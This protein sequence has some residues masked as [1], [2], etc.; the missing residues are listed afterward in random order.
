MSLKMR[1]ILNIITP[2][3]R[4][5]HLNDIY[6]SISENKNENVDIRWWIIFDKK[7]N[8]TKEVHFPNDIEIHQFFSKE[9]TIAGHGHRNKILSIL[10]TEEDDKEEEWIYNLDDDNIIHPG[11]IDYFNEIVVTSNELRIANKI[12]EINGIIFSQAMKDGRLRL[13]ADRNN[14]TLCNVDT[15]QFVFK[16]K[17]L[18]GLRF[19][20]NYCADGYFIEELYKNNKDNFFVDEEVHCYYNYLKREKEMNI[21]NCPVTILQNEFEFSN[22][23]SIY[24]YYK[25]KKVLEIG[26]FFGGTLWHW[27]EFNDEIETIVSIDYPIPSSDGRYDEMIDSKK[28]WNDWISKH[29]NISF[30][31]IEKE[32]TKQEAIDQAKQIFKND[33]VDFLFID[34][35]HDY[36]TV[37]SDFENYS[38]LVRKGGLIV[39]HDVV[40]CKDVMDLW[41]E[42]KMTYKYIEIFNGEQGGMGIGIIIK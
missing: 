30:F 10:E 17:T 12:P 4:P 8:M 18:N 6:K 5:N 2:C 33:D 14:I 23:L 20:D 32:S 9:S 35:G 40:G 31:S 19:Y 36:K 26:T 39:L 21:N 22:L 1:N 37:K 13:L 28:K 11:F 41:A 27:L 29:K 24:Q 34:G 38:K 3:T 7:A 42:I 25:P 15:A 16:L